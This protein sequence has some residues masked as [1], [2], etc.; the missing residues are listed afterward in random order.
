M[1]QCC[2]RFNIQGNFAVLPT[3]IIITFGNP[4][5][6]AS[7]TH[8]LRVAP[9]LNV[10][11]LDEV[12][13]LCDQVA[14]GAVT[15]SGKPLLRMNLATYRL[16]NTCQSDAIRELDKIRM[17]PPVVN[18]KV[19]GLYKHYLSPCG[20]IKELALT[21]GPI[22]RGHLAAF[23]CRVFSG[24]WTGVFQLWLAGRINHLCY[25]DN[26]RWAVLRG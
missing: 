18:S 10:A 22:I 26:T 23:I 3:L 21:F 6:R 14:C 5:T 12:D 2:H 17:K 24:Y 16:I 13:E 9:G 15:L 4:E 1:D 25:I 19:F 20:T 11:K 7:E 8:V